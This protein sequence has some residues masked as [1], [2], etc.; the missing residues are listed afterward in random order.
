MR[1]SHCKRFSWQIWT[2]NNQKSHDGN[3][4][5][6]RKCPQKSHGKTHSVLRS[7]SH[8]K[9]ITAPKGFVMFLHKL[10]STL[11]IV[12]KVACSSIHSC[13]Y[14]TIHDYKQML[15]C[16][17]KISSES[18]LEFLLPMVFFCPLFHIMLSTQM[19]YL[20]RYGNI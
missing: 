15:T 3:S 11:N 9:G 8:L 5:R 14:I 20:C 19:N 4:L 12:I 2:V 1:V 16:I 7:I 18:W 13:S 17:H 10:K 6:Q